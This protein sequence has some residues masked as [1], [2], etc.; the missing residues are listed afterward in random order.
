MHGTQSTEVSGAMWEVAL[1]TAFD[2]N[3]WGFCRRSGAHKQTN[4]QT[5]KQWSVMGGFTWPISFLCAD[6][7]RVCQDAIAEHNAP[8]CVLGDLKVYSSVAD[9][10]ESAPEEEAGAKK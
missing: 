2:T 10:V 9:V 6:W 3:A 7:A 5:N 4:K 1:H 8:R